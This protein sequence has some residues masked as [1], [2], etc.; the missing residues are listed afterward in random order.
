MIHLPLFILV[1]W[2]I[3]R[4]PSI[5][6]RSLTNIQTEK[7][8]EVLLAGQV[9]YQIQQQI[10]EIDDQ[11][12]IKYLGTISR[13]DAIQL[14]YNADLLLLPL[15][16]AKNANGRLPGKLYEYLRTFNPILALGPLEGDAAKILETTKTGICADYEDSSKQL[17]FIR[18]CLEKP[19]EISPDVKII[20]QFSNIKQTEKIAKLLHDIS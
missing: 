9:D 14:A 8:I 7:K 4:D 19:D 2:G 18:K 16:K 15:N 12:N 6:L 11:I 20:S 17:N 3:D 10:K 5:F 13:L 1:Y